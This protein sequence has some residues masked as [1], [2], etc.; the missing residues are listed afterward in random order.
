MRLH[1]IAV[2]RLKRA[3]AAAAS[4]DYLKRASRYFPAT[5][6]EVRDAARGR[7]EDA[8]R[9]RAEEAKALR[10]AIPS[11]GRVIALD[12]R[13]RGWG[14]RGFAA[15]IA[16][17]RDGGARSLSFLIGGPDGLDEALKAEA[18]ELMCLGQLTL[19]HE[20]ARVVLCEQLYRAGAILAG[21]P[22]HRD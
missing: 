13:G 22:Y 4:E 9:W 15:W 3:W 10:A 8:A 6:T 16:A 17:Q 19:P 11:G 2:G 18:D 5:L 14:S 7:V 20:L 1:V 12:E 21:A